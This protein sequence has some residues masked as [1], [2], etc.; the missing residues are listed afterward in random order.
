MTMVKLYRRGAVFLVILLVLSAIVGYSFTATTRLFHQ[1]QAASASPTQYVN[2]FVGTGGSGNT[3][4][5]V[6]VPFGEGPCSPDTTGSAHGASYNYKTS[7]ITRF[8]LTHLIVPRIFVTLG[9]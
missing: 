6:T 9:T 2:P 8:S 7:I 5:G 4:P 1:A 3:F